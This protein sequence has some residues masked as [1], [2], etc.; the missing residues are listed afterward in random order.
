MRGMCFE[1]GGELR[2]DVGEVAGLDRPR[3]PGL[4]LGPCVAVH[5]VALPDDHVARAADSV[6]VSGETGGNVGGAIARDQSHSPGL[7]VRVDG[8]QDRCEGSGCGAGADFDADRVGEAADE[9]EMGSAGG[10]G[11][12]ADPYEVGRGVIVASWTG[13]GV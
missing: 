6:D 9:F 13:R 2:D 1:D 7:P 3:R 4:R 8:G 10:A 11:A 5:R 12:V